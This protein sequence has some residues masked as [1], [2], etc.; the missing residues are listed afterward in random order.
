[1]TSAHIVCDWCVNF[2]RDLIMRAGEQNLV[3]V[4]W[5]AHGI[6]RCLA[7]YGLASR[8]GYEL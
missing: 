1:M 3:Q 7:T 2:I 5:L 6:P 8:I 4:M